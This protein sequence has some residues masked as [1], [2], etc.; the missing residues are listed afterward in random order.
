MRVA[1]SLSFLGAA[2]AAFTP[3]NYTLVTANGAWLQW[4]GQPFSTWV[5]LPIQML[6]VKHWEEH[7]AETWRKHGTRFD[8]LL[9]DHRAVELEGYKAAIQAVSDH[10][11][12]VAFANCGW[13]DPCKGVA[14]IATVF[15]KPIVEGTAT[16]GALVGAGPEADA[17]YAFFNRICIT[18]EIV[19][20]AT[21]K[22]L[23]DKS[24][25]SVVDVYDTEH[26]SHDYFSGQ[27]NANGIIV[28]SSMAI[29]KNL[30]D[31]SWSNADSITATIDAGDERIVLVYVLLNAVDGAWVWDDFWEPMVDGDYQI[32]CEQTVGLRQVAQ[33]GQSG[34][35][36]PTQRDWQY[37]GP[38]N[39]T[40]SELLDWTYSNTAS[41]YNA[42]LGNANTPLG[43]VQQ[44]YECANVPGYTGP[45]EDVFDCTFGAT[46][47]PTPLGPGPPVPV[48]L[49]FFAG[50]AQPAIN[51]RQSG[52]YPS[53]V[54]LSDAAEYLLYT[55]EIMMDADEDF[56]NPDA[57]QDKLRSDAARFDG[58]ASV[59]S[60][61]EYGQG[62]GPCSILCVRP[63][64]TGA[65]NASGNVYSVIRNAGDAAFAPGLNRD[66]QNDILQLDASETF[67]DGTANCLT[68]NCVGGVCG[69][70]EIYDCFRWDKD[71]NSGA[72]DFST[73]N[74]PTY[75]K[76]SVS[77]SS[78]KAPADAAVAVSDISRA[79]G[80]VGGCASTA[81]LTCSSTNTR[82]LSITSS[83][84]TVT[85][86]LTGGSAAA[87]NPTISATSTTTATVSN[88]QEDYTY[89][90]EC[91]VTTDGGD[92]PGSSSEDFVADGFIN[93]NDAGCNGD[94]AACNS[95]T[96][97]CYCSNDYSTEDVPI[98]V[99]RSC[100]SLFTPCSDAGGC[101]GA[102][103][104]CSST[105]GICEC[106][107][108]TELAA[109]VGQDGDA[110]E[111][112]VSASTGE[113]A[114]DVTGADY[115][116]CVLAVAS[117]A[118]TRKFWAISLWLSAWGLLASLWVIWEFI[119]NAQLKHPNSMMQMFIA[120]AV[121]DLLLSLLNFVFYIDSLVDGDPLGSVTGEGGRDDDGCLV[122]SFFI[123]TIVI[124]TYFA[125]T[126]VALVTF[127]KF[128]AVSQGKASFALPS[129]AVY[130]M[131]VVVP[132]VIGAALAGG[133]LNTDADDDES[134]LGS[135]RGLYCYIRRYDDGMTG[136]VLIVMFC[137]STVV[138]LLFYILTTLKVAAIVKNATS[139]G[140]ANAPKAIMKRGI[141]L[142]VTFVATWLWFVCTGGIAY[143]EE[144]IEIDIDMVGA[145]VINAQPIIDAV[146]LLTLPN[147]RLDYLSRWLK[148]GGGS[149]SSGGGG[150][151]SSSSS[152]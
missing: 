128:N 38:P 79:T 122:V 137:I 107:D 3:G 9:Y 4:I 2:L 87:P 145:I 17:N 59:V 72:G 132:L 45:G 49:N 95:G 126:N 125:P 71:G 82:S 67:P 50:P 102:Y 106:Q 5:A 143:Q 44:P 36:I 115:R 26:P 42:N 37:V 78:F 147:V 58:Y 88:L 92:S 96:G 40:S 20:T 127:L 27:A 52:I 1:V 151:G 34:V 23:N 104:S 148:Q 48:T 85:G 121:P 138:T 141:L 8:W 14:T 110:A 39:R 133:A 55:L 80:C 7:N 76:G 16:M 25:T 131:G 66:P 43:K 75:A 86:V 69:C 77:G 10:P 29:S 124:M 35:L 98:R 11:D 117:V 30:T 140:A 47:Y 142:T 120:F 123:Y 129:A 22:L 105:T 56:T 114:G 116:T 33:Y 68:A 12:M 118:E 28:A 73:T 89:T 108:G 150:G 99:T 139:A 144:T 57:L 91:Y 46:V 51:A 24:W 13:D 109:L 149:V 15:K 6:V 31:F 21:A 90:A 19:V 18:G 146:I 60:M 32:I 97:V 84:F 130:G 63:D 81:T 100:S 53:L 134:V 62:A 113:G 112:F 101:L 136:L 64:T 94:N 54:G 65:A 83:T 119:F 70:I 61:S 93:C 41:W 74:T 152:S 103:G 111:Y 135:Y